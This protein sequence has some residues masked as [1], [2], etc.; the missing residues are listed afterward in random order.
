MKNESCILYLSCLS[1]AVELELENFSCD[2][3]H[4]QADQSRANKWDDE[5]KAEILGCC[6][7]LIQLFDLNP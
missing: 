1:A 4:L 6:R 3:C 7:F 5:P 2:G